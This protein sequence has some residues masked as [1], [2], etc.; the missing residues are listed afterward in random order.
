MPNISEMSFCFIQILHQHVKLCIRKTCPCNEYPL[1]PNFYIAKLG[2]AGIYLFFL[3]FAPKH[4][5]WVLVRAAS[6]R[7]FQR[8]PTIYVLIK[9]KKNTKSFLLKIFIFHTFKNLC[10]LHGQVFVMGSNFYAPNFKELEGPYWFGSVRLS[11]PFQCVSY[12]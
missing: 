9:N 1:K 6:A 12:A 11:S 3:I 2:Y 10:I 4:R 5:L 7:Q 8:V